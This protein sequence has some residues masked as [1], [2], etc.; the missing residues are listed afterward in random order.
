MIAIFVYQVF[1]RKKKGTKPEAN[2]RAGSGLQGLGNKKGGLGGLSEEEKK[3]LNKYQDT[4]KNLNLKTNE[5][6]KSIEKMKTDTGKLSELED[7]IN[8]FKKTI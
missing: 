3:K 4:F 5:L 7:S 2:N 6:T 1:F 8:S